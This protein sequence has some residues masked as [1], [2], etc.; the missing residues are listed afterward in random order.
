MRFSTKIALLLAVLIIGSSLIQFF[1]FDR[2]FL[3][4]SDELLAN[5]TQTAARSAGEHL[6]AYF[7][8]T[9]D[10]VQTLA[11]D[12]EIK[13]NRLQLEKIKSFLPEINMIFVFD[14]N[15][16]VLNSTTSTAL[17]RNLAQRDYFIRAING[18]TTI[19]NV[20]ISQGNRQVVMIATPLLENGR[21]NG[22]VAASVW[23]QDNY[24]SALFDNKTFSHNGIAMITDP[25]GI[26]VYH[27][28]K[29]RIGQKS[30]LS[31]KLP[32]AAGTL[33]TSNDAAGENQYIG[34]YRLPSSNWL[35]TVQTPTAE[36]TKM[37][38][39]MIVQLVAVS[40]ATLC[41]A[42]AI[43]AY[44]LRR[45][46]RPFEDLVQA[47][48]CLR[49]GDYCKLY[50]E[51]YNREF[52][53]VVQ[54]YNLTVMRLKNLHTALR[55]AADIDDLTG[56]YNRRAFERALVSLH[57]EVQDG[58]LGGFTILFIDL[59]NFKE[60]NDRQG[61]SAGD[62]VLRDFT[63]LTRS[64]VEPHAVFRFGGDEFVII[65]RDFSLEEAG[66]LAEQIRLLSERSLRG[67]TVSIGIAA[68]PDHSD[69]V[70]EVLALADKALYNSKKHKNTVTAAPIP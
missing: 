42:V 18:E 33:T 1:A 17:G 9:R 8:R 5:A 15:G 21:I 36:L 4:A 2:L 43:A 25:Q 59:D 66:A 10:L 28:N 38:H 7:T 24:L 37:R 49:K 46:F 57:N 54:I 41:L 48:S 63:G 23:L 62:A 53:E 61:H 40:L 19:S 55:G 20:F 51:H 12:P 52:R 30:A 64:L 11:A 44:T 58:G 22:V 65:L 13:T 6:T 32:E 39:Q 16:N 67:C 29:S 69:S 70:D 56:T 3:T 68:Y 27:S 34:Y 45:S 47:F 31:N 35:V 60:I 26:I 14:V 50:P